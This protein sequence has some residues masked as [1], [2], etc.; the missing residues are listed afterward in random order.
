MSNWGFLSGIRKKPI[1]FGI[2]N[3]AKFRPQNQL[4]E[5]PESL[6]RGHEL[7]GDT[8]AGVNLTVALMHSPSSLLMV[9]RT[10]E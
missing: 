2:G 4:I 6:N 10:L 3:V 9:S 7:E 8:G 1:F 5:G